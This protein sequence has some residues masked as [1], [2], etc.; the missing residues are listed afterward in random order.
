MKKIVISGSMSLYPKMKNIANQ[1]AEMGYIVVIP[2]PVDWSGISESEFSEHRKRLSMKHFSEIA[3]EDTYAVLVVND[4]KQGIA[5]YIGANTFAEIALAFYFG[6]KIFIL[7]DI[8]DLYKDELA[9]WGAI[10][11]GGELSGLS[12]YKP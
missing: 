10:P 9:A 6:K 2:Q 5:S 1:L 4:T 3:N 12:L 7:N 11:L 8:Y